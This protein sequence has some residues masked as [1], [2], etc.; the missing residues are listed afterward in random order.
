MNKITFILESLCLLDNSRALNAY[1]FIDGLSATG[2]EISIVTAYEEREEFSFSNSNIQIYRP[3]KN[4]SFLKSLKAYPILLNNNPD[5]CHIFAP[6]TSGKWARMNQ[7]INMS[8]FLKASLKT[9]NSFSGFDPSFHN[10]PKNK[11]QSLAKQ[12]DHL[13][14]HFYDDL[15]NSL[16]KPIVLPNSLPS[17]KIKVGDDNVLKIQST[18]QDIWEKPELLETLNLF[19]QS[20]PL[21]RIQV[22]NGWGDFDNFS[23]YSQQMY[24]QE[25]NIFRKWHI[26]HDCSLDESSLMLDF[27]EV[28][29]DRVFNAQRALQNN[30]PVITPSENFKNYADTELLNHQ[31]LWLINNFEG[32]LYEKL[33]IVAEN[34]ISATDFN[35]TNKN[36]DAINTFSRALSST[37]SSTL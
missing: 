2:Y 28:L 4:F 31:G 23:K 22:C 27:S 3:L 21:W 37:D 34:K 1:H 11:T 8:L 5:Y 12:F 25:K 24:W 10:W 35:F 36:D 30:I 9:K 18:F 16:N 14:S 19:L 6:F 32:S 29:S 17:K 13:F 20:Y 33:M 7:L 26:C 15:P